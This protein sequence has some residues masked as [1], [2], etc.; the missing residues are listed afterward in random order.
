[1]DRTFVKII[2][3]NGDFLRL[4]LKVLPLGA[5]S[6]EEAIPF[7]FLTKPLKECKVA[8]VTTTGVHLPT[9]E[10]FNMETRRGDPTYRECH[11]Q[12]LKKHHVVSHSHYNST[13]LEKDINIG[14]PIDI[15]KELADQN[16]IHSLNDYIYSFMGYI[17][18]LKPLTKQYAPEVAGKLKKQSVDIVFLTPG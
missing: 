8:L 17:V 15:I 3:G 2:R 1:M 5:R 18:D 16:I 11:W 13:G 14:V 7:N 9:Q 6:K 4:V 10:P 12:E